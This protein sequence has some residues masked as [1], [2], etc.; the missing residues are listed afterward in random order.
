MTISDTVDY[1][2]HRVENSILQESKDCI[3]IEEP[4]EIAIRYFKDSEWIVEPLM[5][6][7]RTP[8]DDEALVSGYFFQRALSRIKLPLIRLKLMVKIRV[9]TMLIIR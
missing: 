3:A 2:I 6:T 4:L 7:M 1:E 9:N 5:V 8:G